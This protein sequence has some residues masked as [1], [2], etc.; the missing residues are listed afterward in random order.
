MFSLTDADLGKKIV[1]CADGPA[2]FDAEMAAP[3]KRVLSFDPI[4]R[5]SCE[6]IASRFEESVDS[7]IDRVRANPESWSWKYHRDPDHLLQNRRKALEAFL[8]D[9]ALPGASDGTPQ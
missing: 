8:R 6:E 2:S 5:F 9:F 1:G 4:Y 7:V 3:G